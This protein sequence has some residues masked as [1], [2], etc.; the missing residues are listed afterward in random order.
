MEPI[1]GNK[2]PLRCCICEGDSPRSISPREST[3]S[4]HNGTPFSIPAKYHHISASVISCPRIRLPK[5]PA[6]L[7]PFFAAQG[8]CTTLTPYLP[9]PSI[10]TKIATII[11]HFY[12]KLSKASNPFFCAGCCPPWPCKPP[13]PGG[14]AELNAPQPCCCV[15]CWGCCDHVGGGG[16]EKGVVGFCC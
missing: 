16:R 13:C 15:G 14:G 11:I 7:Q 10:S 1:N 2:L 4:K 8:I 5:H 6:K 9:K 3:A 12:N